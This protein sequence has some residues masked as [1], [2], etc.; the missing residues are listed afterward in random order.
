[1]QQLKMIS[2]ACAGCGAPIDAKTCAAAEAS[3]ASDAIA[4]AEPGALNSCKCQYR[5][6]HLVMQSAFMHMR[7]KPLLAVLLLCNNG[8]GPRFPEG[9][10]QLQRINWSAFKSILYMYRRVAGLD[11]SQPGLN[12]RR[13]QPQQTR[14]WHI[15]PARHAFS[16]LHIQL[17]TTMS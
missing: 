16:D 1:M 11:C 10:L 15:R 13:E 3:A 6:H 8:R 7:S 9:A 12:V 2:T 4:E 5:C 17:T 14:H